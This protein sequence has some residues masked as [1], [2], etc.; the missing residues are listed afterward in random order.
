MQKENIFG[1]LVL[2][3][4]LTKLEKTCNTREKRRQC[5]LKMILLVVGVALSSQCC[6]IYRGRSASGDPPNQGSTDP[7]IA[8]LNFPFTLDRESCIVLA[9]FLKGWSMLGS[10]DPFPSS[11]KL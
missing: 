5:E 10:T 6:G 2:W 7:T 1:F 11:T 8:H 3:L 9:K 4:L